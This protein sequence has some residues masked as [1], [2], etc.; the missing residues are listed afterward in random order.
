MSTLGPQFEQPELDG[1]PAP[2]KAGHRL[3]KYAPTPGVTPQLMQRVKT[4]EDFFAKPVAPANDYRSAHV[5]GKWK[6]NPLQSPDADAEFKQYYDDAFYYKTGTEF[7]RGHETEFVPTWRITSGQSE[8]SEDAIKHQ[9]KNA[10][11]LA[12]D[13]DPEVTEYPAADGGT[14]YRVSDG[15]HRVNAALRRGQLF[16]PAKVDRYR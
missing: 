4:T 15:N 12:L 5:M 9:V 16:M 7:D 11:P 1:M 3:D 14:S 2:Q 8:V 13:D 6:A 10:N